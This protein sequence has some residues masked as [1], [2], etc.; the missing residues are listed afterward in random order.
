MFSRCR[1]VG[2][3]FAE[4]LA[5][6]PL[7]P[8]ASEIQQLDLIVQLLGTPNESIWPGFLR[9][10][11]VGQYSLRKQ[12]YNNLK[13]KFTWLSE[14]GLR[15]LNLLFMYNPQRRATAKDCLESSYF[16]E[17]PLPCEPELMPTFPHHRNKRGA[18]G[19]ENQSKRSKV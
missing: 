4:L 13:N 17:K 2:C 10:P 1:A 3:I 15:L 6:K 5:H 8:G 7:L 16:K 9:L 14:A 19:T 12:P 18:S 11:L